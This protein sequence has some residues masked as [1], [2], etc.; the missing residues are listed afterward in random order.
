MTLLRSGSATDTGLVRSVNQ[1]LAVETSTL[2]AV[3]DGMGGHAGGEVA[4][5]LAVD[6]LAVGLRAA[7]HRRRVCPRR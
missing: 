3:A 4:A 2:F 7:A 5:R 6:A 1:D